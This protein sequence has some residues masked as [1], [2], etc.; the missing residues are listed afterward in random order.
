MEPAGVFYFKIHDQVFDTDKNS[1]EA[2]ED[3]SGKF[4]RAYSMEGITIDDEALY[5]AFDSDFYELAAEG[6]SSKSET[7]PVSFVKKSQEYKATGGG[8]L[9]T[10]DE[11]KELCDEAQRQVERICQ[12]IYAGNIEVAPRRKRKPDGK[13]VH[14]ACSYCDYK[15]ICMFDISFDGCEYQDV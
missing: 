15:S 9:L 2:G 5:E 10:A 7:I 11:F 12:E 8:E 6:K 3:V 14:N 13:V 4:M 1:E